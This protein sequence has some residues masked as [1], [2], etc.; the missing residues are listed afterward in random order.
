MNTKEYIKE[1]SIVIVGILIA[2]WIN[3]VW[4]RHEHHKTQK[5]VLTVIQNELNDN[6][7]EIKTALDNLGS[8]R[9]NFGKIQQL[10]GSSGSQDIS[11]KYTGLNFKSVGYETA[12]Y[13]GILKDI[14][15]NLMSEIVEYYEIQKNTEDLEA[16]L[17]DEIFVF[18]K[19][20]TPNN[21]DYL[22]LKISNLIENIRNLEA[23][24][25][26]LSEELAGYF[27]ESK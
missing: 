16:S 15:H 9:N 8:L 23:I 12:K 2:L 6:K 11:I 14:S 20:S 3:N 21:I 27:D 22:I 19:N 17:K 25:N 1:L 4:T 7:Q 13:T 18:F 24:Q 26:Q 10:S 5:Q